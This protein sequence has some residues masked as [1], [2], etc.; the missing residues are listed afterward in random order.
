MYEPFLIFNSEHGIRIIAPW[1]PKI[2][3]TLLLLPPPAKL[4]IHFCGPHER[5]HE[6][7]HYPHYTTAHK[8]AVAGYYGRDWT[9]IW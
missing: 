9:F 7:A 5:P 6:R 8:S 2:F 1:S 4:V 3:T